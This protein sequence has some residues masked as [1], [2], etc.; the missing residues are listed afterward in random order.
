MSN[1]APVSF[2]YGN[3]AQAEIMDMM[4]AGWTL[5]DGSPYADPSR[6]VSPEQWALFDKYF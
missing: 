2:G 4:A 1:L 5:P 3:N 6:D